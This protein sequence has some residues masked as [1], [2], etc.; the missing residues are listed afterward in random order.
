MTDSPSP[1]KATSRRTF[2]RN[3]SLI[4]AG[5]AIATGAVQAQI[6]KSAHAFGSDTIKVGLVGCGGR[7]SQ[8]IQQ[9]MN[10]TGGEVKL[11]AMA[12]A[13]DSRLQRSL[14]GLSRAKPDKVEVPKDRQFVG[15]NAYKD[16]MQTNCDMVILSTPPGFRP[17]HF[18]AAV[19]AG[20]QIFSEKPVAVDA[21]G[22]RKF[23]AANEEAKKKGLAV[24]IGLQRRHERKYMATVKAIQD[25]AIGDIV[26]AR[27]YW[28]GTK[29]WF[30]TRMEG[31][32]EMAYQ[33]RNW[34]NFVWTCGDHIVE[35]HI[36]NL[37]VINWIK[38]DYPATA[39]GQGGCTLREKAFGEIYDHHMVEFTYGDGT[40]LLSECRHQPNTWTSV[41][42]HVHGTKGRADVSGS[43]IYDAD[44]KMIHNF[45]PKNDAERD[46]SQG[47]QQ[48]H[49]DLFAELRAGK[50][51]QEGEWGAKSTM[52]AIFGRMATYSGQT[53]K[54]DQCLNSEI[55]ES[56]VEKFTSFDDE[57]P[58]KPD[59]DG[60]YALPVPGKT[61]VV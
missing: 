9:A 26:L 10:T 7:G 39:Q 36:H 19:E 15:L 6:A 46:L 47:H 41:A 53:M 5:S 25:G 2:L 28:N 31:E 59:A 42:E 38:N 24:A 12:D 33:M 17:L 23:L 32:T 44:G 13:F 34:Y 22:V 27:A 56:P 52:T 40:V 51:P 1:N 11:V 57:P 49:H 30:F 18:A 8:A 61:K 37:D 14:G 21:P 60:W 43:K 3:S 45:N 48:E 54:W 35:Q 50:T 20:K 29:P 58:H 55:V 4:V 16:L